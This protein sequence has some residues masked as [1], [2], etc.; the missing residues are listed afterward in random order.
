M[1]IRSK[2]INV[3]SSQIMA[4]AAHHNLPD[5]LVMSPKI[6]FVLVRRVFAE[7]HLRRIGWQAKAKR[8]LV[9]L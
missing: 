9:A 4:N 6:D 3:D 2:L 7:D 1:G 8:K 5:A